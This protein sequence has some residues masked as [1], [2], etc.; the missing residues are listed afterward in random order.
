LSAPTPAELRANLANLIGVLGTTAARASVDEQLAEVLQWL[1]AHPGW[2][3]ILDN[4][5]TEEAAEEVQ[6]LLAR[7]RAGHVLI[8][9]RIGNW[10]TGVEPLELD[11]LAPAD[12]AAF[13]LERTPHRRKRADDAT[14]AG[15][16]A[17]E[18]DG[19]ALALEQA[20]A[21]VDKLRLSLAEY[22]QRWE[23]ERPEV[24]GGHDLG[25]MQSPAGVGVTW[26]TTFAQLAEP[27][28]RLLAVLSWLA[29]EPFPL[30]LLDAPPLARAIPDPREALAILA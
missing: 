23:S 16:I 30:F 27:E 8:T 9:S 15:A 10:G 14:R 19:L 25:L 20:G 13:L 6:R 29:P 11:V 22:L 24:R 3:L 28:Q 21:Y 1:D 2:L 7:L 26:E 12:A 18:L 4:V 5:D 17:G